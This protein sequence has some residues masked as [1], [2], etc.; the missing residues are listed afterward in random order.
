MSVLKAVV[1]G[2]C[3]VAMLAALP[4]QAQSARVVTLSCA[5]DPSVVVASNSSAGSPIVDLGLPCAQALAEVLSVA[6]GDTELRWDVHVT[7]VGDKAGKEC[8][9]YTVAENLRGPQGPT[10][11]QGPS[12]PPGAPGGPGPVGPQGVPGP[13]GPPGP[14]GPP[15]TPGGFAGIHILKSEPIENT[16]YVKQDR[17]YC[18]EGEVVLSGGYYTTG[19]LTVNVAE[20]A[21]FVNLNGQQAW[22]VLAYVPQSPFS[23]DVQWSLQVYAICAPKG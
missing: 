18:P 14:T 22:R 9:T 13:K 21:P 1:R 19:A 20:S 23:P 15:G 7:S 5:Q 17:V 11:P 4:A 10:G 3:V 8:V 12:G 16:I 6:P 2:A